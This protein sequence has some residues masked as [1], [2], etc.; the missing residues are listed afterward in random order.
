MRNGRYQVTAYGS[1]GYQQ[2]SN[3]AFLT[4]NKGDV[5]HL[6]LQEGHIYEHP[7]DEA[8]ISFT[9]FMLYRNTV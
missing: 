3:S 2:A 5:I 1:T 6:E 4:L 9:G 8:Y 7:D